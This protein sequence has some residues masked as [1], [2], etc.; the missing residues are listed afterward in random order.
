MPE[1]WL[2]LGSLS[3][4]H[5]W[6]R[7]VRIVCSRTILG[8]KNDE[9]VTLAALAVVVGLEVTRRLRETKIIED[10]VVRVGGV[11][12]LRNRRVAVRRRGRPASAPVVLKIKRRAR[13]AVVGLPCR[14][15]VGVGLSNGVV[16]KYRSAYVHKSSP[17]IFNKRT[18][19]FMDICAGWRRI[20][21]AT[22]IG[23]FC[24][25]VTEP[26]ELGVLGVPWIRQDG[27]GADVRVVGTPRA[28][29]VRFLSSRSCI[30]RQNSLDL[31]FRVLNPVYNAVDFFVGL[32]VDVCE[33]PVVEHI[34]LN[35]PCQGQGA[36]CLD[37]VHQASLGILL[38]T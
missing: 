15:T 32:S 14:S 23:V 34:S 19:E 31:E 2:I 1:I 12:E 38:G 11:E 6:R 16:W 35:S 33:Q 25:S 22:G 17:A 26:S 3:I 29:S 13:W 20:L 27:T 5:G 9:I 18:I 37:E 28:T 30:R 10:I 24:S 8:V 4:T 21:T 36:V 7:E